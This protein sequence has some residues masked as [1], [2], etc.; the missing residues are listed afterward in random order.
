[1]LDTNDRLLDDRE[2]I[3]R[4]QQ[5]DLDALG[6]LFERYRTRVYRTALA[7]VHEPQVAEDILQ[8]CFL[9]VYL[10]AARIDPSRPLAPWLY[11]VTVNLSYTWLSRGKG[12][13]TPI[14]HVVDYLVS[15]MGH[16]PDRVAEQVE[17]RQKVREAIA[18]LNIDQRVVVVLYYLNNL[19]LQVI[20]EILDLPVGT[21]KSRLYYARENLRSKLGPNMAW[22]PEVAHGYI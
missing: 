14:E 4:L 9:K 8:D 16:A 15:P 5:A 17:L 1:M 21:V 7:I 19:N 12:R 13:R 6:Q 20:A 18:D 22:L 11:R 10:N 3:E 2:L